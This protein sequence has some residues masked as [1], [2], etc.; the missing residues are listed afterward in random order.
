MRI[1]HR[2]VELNPGGSNHFNFRERP[3]IPLTP[4]FRRELQ[5][6]FSSDVEKLGELLDRDLSAWTRIE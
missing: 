4:E 6:Y 3:R 1:L 2:L 5:N